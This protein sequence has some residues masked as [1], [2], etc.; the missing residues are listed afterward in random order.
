MSVT[1]ELFRVGDWYVNPTSEEIPR[2]RETIPLELGTMR[3]LACLAEQPGQ[4]VSIEDLYS[5]SPM[6]TSE[7]S[8]QKMSFDYPLCASQPAS[9]S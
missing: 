4:V 8:A 6:G 9:R 2:D 5:C 7:L 1:A 3:L